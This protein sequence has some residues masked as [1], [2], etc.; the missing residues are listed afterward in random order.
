MALMKTIFLVLVI[1]KKTF[2]FT[3]LELGKGFKSSSKDRLRKVASQGGVHNY[4]LLCLEA[5]LPLC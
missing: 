1:Q 5:L 3:F 4:C 2:L